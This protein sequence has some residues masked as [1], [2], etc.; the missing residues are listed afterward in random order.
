[1][2]EI[3]RDEL[4]NKIPHAAGYD[5]RAAVTSAASRRTMTEKCLA[6]VQGRPTLIA[7]HDSL[8]YPPDV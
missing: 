3:I 2:V 7:F 4:K 1:M 5:Q 8:R 6:K